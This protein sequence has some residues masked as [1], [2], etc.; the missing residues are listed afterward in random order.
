M[1]TETLSELADSHIN[2]NIN[3]VKA[4]VKHMT[5]WEFFLLLDFIVNQS[6]NYI[7]RV[8]EILVK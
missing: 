3:Y 1:K 6:D 7:E 2:G 8:A 4:K 5:K